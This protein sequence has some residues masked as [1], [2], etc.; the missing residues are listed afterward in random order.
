MI[1]LRHWKWSGELGKCGYCHSKDKSRKV[2]VG[3]FRFWRKTFSWM[4][5][6]CEAC[7]DR[8]HLVRPKLCRMVEWRYDFLLIYFS[9]L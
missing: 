4:N 3:I 7:I 8:R 9:H 5:V 1:Y 2:A 6:T